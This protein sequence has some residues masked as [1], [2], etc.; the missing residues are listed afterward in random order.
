MATTIRCVTIY[1]VAKE[2]HYRNEDGTG[3]IETRYSYSW[4][5]DTLQM[6]ERVTTLP[7]IAESQNGSGI[8]A[9]RTERFDAAGNLVWLKDERGYIT[10][11]TYDAGGNVTRT[12]PGRGRSAASVPGGWSTPAGGGLHS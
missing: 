2:T 5:A 3:A 7:A 11:H 9:T 1:P 12:D 10:Y 8:S 6:Q 4:Y